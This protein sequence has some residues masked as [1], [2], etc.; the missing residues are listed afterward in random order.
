MGDEHC[1]GTKNGSWKRAPKYPA[2]YNTSRKLEFRLTNG[3]SKTSKHS[4]NSKE[5]GGGAYFRASKKR[6]S[7]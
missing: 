6:G 7:S 4:P 1:A 5:V 2:D 3:N